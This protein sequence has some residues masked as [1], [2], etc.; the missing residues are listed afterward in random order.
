M[1]Q[2][3]PPSDTAL[4][5]IR[6]WFE[7]LHPSLGEWRG[8]IKCVETKEVRYFREWE[9]IAGLIAEM[10]DGCASTRPDT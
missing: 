1:V 6:L 8:E 2:M 10:L 4:F 5:T 9:E 3:S 7:S